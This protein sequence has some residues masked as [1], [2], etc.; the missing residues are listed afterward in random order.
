MDDLQVFSLKL[1]AVSLTSDN[2][3]IFLKLNTQCGQAIVLGFKFKPRLSE[4]RNVN[5]TE[6]ERNLT[7]HN[8]CAY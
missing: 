5:T 1:L 3:C 4:A 6:T 2:L 7:A 8:I